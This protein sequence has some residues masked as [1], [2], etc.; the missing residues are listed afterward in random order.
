MKNTPRSRPTAGEGPEAA[1]PNSAA[2][3]A[4]PFP[5]SA[6]CRF[7]DLPPANLR[8]LHL[9][10]T[11]NPFA[12]QPPLLCGIPLRSL[13][14]YARSSEEND[15]E[16]EGTRRRRKARPDHADH[17]DLSGRLRRAAGPFVQRSHAA[18]VRHS[19][20]S[21]R[22]D[23]DS[24]HQGRAGHGDH[25]RAARGRRGGGGAELQERGSQRGDRSHAGSER[26]VRPP[27][28]AA[29][30]AAERGSGRA[31]RGGDRRA[32]AVERFRPVPRS[33]ARRSAGGRRAL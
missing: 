11:K 10:R 25:R 27:A 24:G 28:R 30:R 17:A 33:A 31:E 22:A 9:H 12:S 3:P 5:P 8:N 13:F 32:D 14:S 4:M 26:R 23:S 29:R 20:G 21:A 6:A 1:P 2:R 16:K 18:A 7:L 19:G 15:H